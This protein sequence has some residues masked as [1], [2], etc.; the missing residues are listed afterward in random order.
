MDVGLCH[1]GLGPLADHV[2]LPLQRI[3]V[4]AR[5]AAD[6]DLFDVG[7]RGASYAANRAAIDRRVS[8]AQDGEPFLAHNPLQYAFAKQARMLLHRQKHQPHAVFAR[9]RQ[10]EAEF[11]G[12]AREELVGNLDDDSRAVPRHRVASA[13]AAVL[14]VDQ[15]LDAL[16][17]DIVG[18]LALDVD[19]KADTAGI[20]FI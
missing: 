9:R 3:L 8:P 16:L 4:H 15:N 2:K 1:V 5:G 17:D 7:L 10:G 18:L 19:H 6:E 20:S 12:L 13:C 14:Q 11:V